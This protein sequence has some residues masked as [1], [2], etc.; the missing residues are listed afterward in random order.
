MADLF[1]SRRRTQHREVWDLLPWLTNGTLSEVQIRR[2]EQHMEK[3][4]QCRNEYQAQQSLQ[5]Q[6]RAEESVVH[7]PHSALRKLVARMDQEK[8]AAPPPPVEHR[9]SQRARWLAAAVVI[10]TVG[11]VSLA[12]FTSWRLHEVR[13]APR[14]ST[15]SAAP[16]LQQPAA[17]VV[18]FSDS[19]SVSELNGLLHS[20]NAQVVAGPNVSGVYT[21]SFANADRQTVAA[22]VDRLSADPHVRF[23]EFVDFKA[24]Q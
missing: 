12:A 21:L 17:R 18:F 22:T 19:M 11:L 3:C 5:E 20:Y 14:Y 24:A 10:Q 9:T 1:E 15:L 8:L 16:A 13:E 7:T 4:V 2:C 23:A 6:I